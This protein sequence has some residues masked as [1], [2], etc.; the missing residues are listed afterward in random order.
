MRIE[1]LGGFSSNHYELTRVVGAKRIEDG[2]LE[3]YAGITFRSAPVNVFVCFNYAVNEITAFRA[4]NIPTPSTLS[5]ARYWELHFLMRVLTP[6]EAEGA[7]CFDHTIG[8][9]L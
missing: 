4:H 6:F 9:P 5:P 7:G 3:R 8:R 2:D 1:R